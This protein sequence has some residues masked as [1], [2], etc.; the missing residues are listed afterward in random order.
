MAPGV[1]VAGLAHAYD[2]PERVGTAS[3]RRCSSQV[4]PRHS[5]P[6]DGDRVFDHLGDRVAALSWPVKHDPMPRASLNDLSGFGWVYEPPLIGPE[7]FLAELNEY[8]ECGGRLGM[9]TGIPGVV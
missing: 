2:V 1:A 6:R 3:G 9:I 7:E 4:P 5:C 8:Y